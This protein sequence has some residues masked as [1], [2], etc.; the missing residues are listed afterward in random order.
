MIELRI[1]YGNS[2]IPYE[3]REKN[4]WEIVKTKNEPI[5]ID[6]VNSAREE[7]ERAIKH[8][9]EFPGLHKLIKAGS[10]VLIT[11]D[12]PTRGTPG[13][14]TLPPILNLLNSLGVPDE[15]IIIIFACGTHRAVKSEE[16]KNLVGGE[17]FERVICVNHDCDALDL[18]EI[19]T[20]SRNN[21]VKIN[22]LAEKVDYIIGTGKVEY[23][24]YAGYC[25]G[26]KTILPGISGRTTI[27]RNHAMLIDNKAVT[28]N[29]VGNPL[30][31]DM[32]EAAKMSKL[33]FIVNIVQNTKKNLIRAFVGNF[34]EAHLKAIKLYDSLYRIKVK[35]LAD[36]VLVGAGFPKDINLFQ[37]HK[38][39][40]NAQRIV[41]PGGVIVA[42]LE[43]SEGIG[44][45]VFYK[46]AKTYRTV[47]ELETQ[48]MTNFE[49]GG[50]KA[51]YMAK[52]QEKAK[53]ILISKINPKEV[54][55]IFMIEPSKTV[56]DA[57]D[58]AYTWAGRDAKVTFM[59]HGSITFPT[60]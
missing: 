25:G 21:K 28:G 30:H 22:A 27:N 32:I 11:Q 41:R 44:H 58:L 5:G 48:I 10:H 8:P 4:L 26:R 47:E 18:V 20:T 7:I 42:A 16:Q 9:I 36:I 49:M 23:H 43:C 3:I 33:S 31:E 19:G 15:N 57:M 24:Y 40:D 14:V 34:I 29:L 59:P 46:W 39:L 55:D 52:L 54:R 2:E 6:S 1:K 51:Y 17:V 60:L 35:S 50:H 38:A 37:A 12:D 56:E 53:I 45:Q 13:Y